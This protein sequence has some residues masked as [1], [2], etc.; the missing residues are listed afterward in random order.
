MGELTFLMNRDRG[1]NAFYGLA[2]QYFTAAGA[3]LVEA[4]V[5]G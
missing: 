2:K 5:N 4:P 1:T 3:D